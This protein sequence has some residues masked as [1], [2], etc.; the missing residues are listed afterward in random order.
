MNFEALTMTAALV[1]ALV[2]PTH[3]AAQSMAAP[4]S[5]EH[6]HNAW[7]S[8]VRMGETK[9]ARAATSAPNGNTFI[10]EYHP[11]NSGCTVPAVMIIVPQEKDVDT[12]WSNSITG[13]FRID[14]QP[15]IHFDG[16][17]AAGIGD[18]FAII[19][20]NNVTSP[21]RFL[22]QVSE[23]MTLRF[24]VGDTASPAVER[25]SLFGASLAMRRAMFL[26]AQL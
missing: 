4:S 9:T 3:A 7:R 2:V 5:S 12:P 10:L 26:C 18:K 19:T 20:V 23:G 24:Q 25:F 13:Q 22:T 16:I 21:G 6:A 14:Q 8:F 11:S 17:H 15:L 1:V